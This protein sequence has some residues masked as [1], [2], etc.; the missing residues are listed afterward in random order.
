[1]KKFFFEG[2]LEASKSLMNRALVLESYAP[3]LS[4]EGFSSS[5]DV[6]VLKN[7]LQA[8]RS[9]EKEF[10]VGEAGTSFRFLALRL[11]REAGDF[12]L[13]GS[14]RL[15]SRPIDELLLTLQ[16]L[17]VRTEL[18]K[19]GLRIQSTGLW[20][21]NS[22]GLIQ[23]QVDNLRSSQFSSAI[24]LNSVNLPAPLE[25]AVLNVHTS[26][27]YLDMTLALC[28]KVGLKLTRSEQAEALFVRVPAM[29]KIQPQIL[30]VE[31]DA[32]SCFALLGCAAVAGEC[33]LGNWPLT[34]IQPDVSGLEALMKMGAHCELTS[35]GLR[36]KAGQRLLSLQWSFQNTPDLFPV[37]AVLASFAEGESCFEDFQVLKHKESDRL[38]N[39]M[40]LLTKA[41][42]SCELRGEKL[43]I[44]G[45]GMEFQPEV[46]E[47]DTDQDHRMAMAAGIFQLR[48]PKINILQPEAV[49]KSFPRF[50]SILR[51]ES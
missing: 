31:A 33:L 37:L 22:S 5:D 8:L 39:T 25:L 16:Q 21:Q 27:A 29:Q 19:E 48:Q 35:K 1:M 46:F 44:Q 14:E 18:S 50:W 11:S 45:R 41:G 12:L 2:N 7:S 51:G 42:I 49:S 26:R 36:V 43:Y 9:G 32:S 34:R 6:K 47:F 24:L 30:P 15:L 38:R 10:W 3:E 20:P 28:E 23:L 17:N 4:I 40:E 13:S